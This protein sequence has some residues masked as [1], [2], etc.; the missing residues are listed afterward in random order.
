MARIRSSQGQRQQGGNP[1]PASPLFAWLMDVVRRPGSDPSEVGQALASLRIHFRNVA[2]FSAA[3][4]V[5]HLSSSLYMMLVYDKVLGSG[6]HVTLFVLTIALAASLLT[7]SWVDAT[8]SRLL[9]RAGLRLD[10]RLGGT[11]IDAVI[12]N[13]A[14]GDTRSSQLLRD[15]DQF[16]ATVTGQPTLALFD[17]P[18]AV[19]FLLVLAIIHWS[20]ALL[21][22][23]GGVLF[24]VV[25]RWSEARM[26]EPTRK[27]NEMTA[28]TNISLEGAL[29]YAGPIRAMGMSPALRRMWQGGRETG[30]SIS[31]AAAYDSAAAT[32]G[33]RF[34][35]L[36]WQSLALGLGAWLAID[37]Q[38]A[39]GAMVA[40]SIL[41][42]RTLTPL[43]Q[44]VGAW[45]PLATAADTYGRLRQALAR[46]A[47]DD[48]A[49]IQLPR[50]R[51]QVDIEGLSVPNPQGGPPI[52]FNVSFQV[53]PGETV[54]VVGSSGA[55]KTSLVRALFGLAPGAAGAVRFD[56]AELSQW[57]SEDLAASVGY[58][59]QE[60]AL[61][62]G[63]VRDNVSRFEAHGAFPP[64]DT[65]A[66]VIAACQLAGVHT[67]ILRLPAG[68]DTPIGAGGVAL[69]GG[70]RQRVALARALFRD[71]A[72]I[73]L[74]EPNAHLDRDGELALMAT[75]QWLRAS[76][77]T[78][79]LVTHRISLLGSTHKVL[80]LAAGRVQNFGPRDEVVAAL[81]QSVRPAV[82]AAGGMKGS[83]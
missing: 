59:P 44:I 14:A 64:A 38:I 58:L 42:G 61:L 10:R 62:T 57:R 3:V 22:I 50:M 28:A 1:P 45:K 12:K 66:A 4:A 15:F 32:G 75:L 8:R 19:V 7:L 29:T 52:L 17:F 40:S 68:Y 43:E 5:L 56:G 71:P 23:I 54:A 30:R 35:R 77:R 70:Q 34:L 46:S 47:E 20:L 76:G 49:K 36:L 67:D 18:W 82:A 33:L 78:V 39:P 27:V 80:S 79:I 63:T 2:L 31:A 24:F 65:D 11:V 53:A 21:A 73:V 48:A 74:D 69:S 16:R 13:S 51:G 25:A 83:A 60:V 72:V 41:I 55:G 37:G 6:S 81:Q 9:I 26:R